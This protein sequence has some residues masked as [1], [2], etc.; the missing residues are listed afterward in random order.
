MSTSDDFDGWIKAAFAE[1]G[2]FT[3]LVLLVR[4]GRRKVTPLRSTFVHVIGDELDWGQIARLFSSAGVTW[5]GA[6]FFPE[7]A[8]QGGPLDSAAARL[9]LR[10]LETRVH[11]DRLVLNEGHFFDAWGRR[12]RVDEVA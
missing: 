4:I 8:R 2:A 1:T 5:D 12:M 11:D 9:K 10:M 6:A 3:A 7:C